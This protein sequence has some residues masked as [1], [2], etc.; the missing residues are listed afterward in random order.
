MKT[1]EGVDAYVHAFLTAPVVGGGWSASRPGRST[2]DERAPVSYCIGGWVG[3]KAGLE[4]V[5]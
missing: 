1:Y 2:P 4:A 3:P 5:E